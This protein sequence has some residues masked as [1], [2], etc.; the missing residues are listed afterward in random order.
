MFPSINPLKIHLVKI[1][2]AKI[3]WFTAEDDQNLWENHGQALTLIRYSTYNMESGVMVGS[4]IFFSVLIGD[5][6]NGSNLFRLGD[7]WVIRLYHERLP[8]GEIHAAGGAA[9]CNLPKQHACCRSR[10]AARRLA[11]RVMLYLW[12]VALIFGQTLEGKLC[13]HWYG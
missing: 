1:R 5:D 6:G 9:P 4:K 3:G 8:R 11:H 13:R 2:R 10:N 7:P 12:W